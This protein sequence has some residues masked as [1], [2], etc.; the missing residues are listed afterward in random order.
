MT[1]FEELKDKT[2]GKTKQIIAE[3]IGDGELAEEGK[4]QVR[5]GEREKDEPGFDPNQLI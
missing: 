2:A 5:K 1:K 4:E 3:V